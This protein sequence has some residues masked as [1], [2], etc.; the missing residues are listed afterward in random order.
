MACGRW[1]WI[2]W[3]EGGGSKGRLLFLR[4]YYLIYFIN[5][6]R[7]SVH[8]TQPHFFVCVY[9]VYP[10]L[11]V[12]RWLHDFVVAAGHSFCVYHHSRRQQP[13]PRFQ[14]EIQTR[15]VSSKA[16]WYRCT[17]LARSALISAATITHNGAAP[18]NLSPEN[19]VHEGLDWL[20]QTWLPCLREPALSGT[21]KVI[22]LMVFVSL[23]SHKRDQ[24]S[25]TGF[26]PFID[27]LGAQAA[28]A[29]ACGCWAISGNINEDIPKPIVC[30][31]RETKFCGYT[32][33]N[34][35]FPQFGNVAET[36]WFKIPLRFRR[37][38]STGNV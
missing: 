20:I 26:V 24:F 28:I 34:M 7:T 3:R 32:G 9:V 37:T 12:W 22:K 29:H 5:F 38:V 2:G 15:L 18:I 1:G 10:E 36:W 27:K 21:H 8:E 25:L 4:F 33:W 30:A 11:Y 31:V 23:I 6:W 14:R 16:S 17:L 35:V 19:V 13:T